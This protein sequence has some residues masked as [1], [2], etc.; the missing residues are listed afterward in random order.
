[1]GGLENE[2]GIRSETGKK[3]RRG[4]GSET[5]EEKGNLEQKLDRTSSER[6]TKRR[7]MTQIGEDEDEE[8]TGLK[9]VR[10]MMKVAW[11]NGGGKMMVRLKANPVLLQFLEGKPDIFVYGEALVSKNTKEI[12]IDGYKRIIHKAERGGVRRGIVIFYRKEYANVI[13]RGSTSKKFD[14]IWVRMK[15]AQEERIFGFFMH[16]E[17]IAK[18]V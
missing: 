3:H 15:T 2:K 1:M 16:P 12:K 9:E 7:G 5:T 10:T 13:T 8:L 18:I 11:W 4:R 14:I 6:K 17:K